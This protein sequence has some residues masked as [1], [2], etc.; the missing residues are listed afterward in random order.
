MLP[1]QQ[2]HGSLGAH[3]QTTHPL[4]THQQVKTYT[5]SKI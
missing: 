5:K 2:G 3:S 4:Q 1:P